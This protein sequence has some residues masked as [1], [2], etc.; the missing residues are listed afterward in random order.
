MPRTPALLLA[1]TLSLL[2]AAVPAQALELEVTGGS[3][4]GPMSLDVHPGYYPLEFMMVVPSFQSG[5]TPLSVFD[6][7]DPRT[8]DIGTDLLSNAWLGACGLDLHMRLG[9][10]QLGAVPAL[11]DLAIYF[12]AFTLLGGP[13]IID[14][15][16]NPAAF[17][18]GIAG[19][20]RQRFA[21]T[22]DDRAFG[23]VLPRLDRRW[24]VV[25]G[26]R[27]QLL[28]QNAHATTDVYDPFTD[29]FA[30]GPML[31]TPR[32]LHTATQLGDG[33]WLITGGVNQTNDPQALCEIY[34]PVLD[35]FTACA[36]MGTPRMG[37]TA[38]LLPNGKVL[39][40]GGL[41]AV[42]VTPTQLQAVR[43]AVDTTELYD[44]LLDSWTPGPNLRTPR[45][46]HAAITRP[47]GKVLLLGGISWDTV[48]IIGWLPAVRATCDLYDPAANSIVAGPSM[49]TSRSMSDPIDLG[50]GRWLLAGGISSLTL[51]NL[52]TPTANAEIY[53]AVANTWTS[54]G[55]MATA[56][57]NHKGF[58][59]G[60]GQFLLAGGGNGTILS[61]VALSSCEVFSTATNT[62]SPGPSLTSARAGAAAF[63][64]PQGQVQFFGGATTGG[65]ITNSTEWYYF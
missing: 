10:Y 25:G 16:S 32:S 31:T 23:V 41:Q 48:I 22:V 37:H 4:P 26:G 58:A 18:L 47:D 52:G 60:G 24:M 28:A 5:P 56:R 17:R 3:T 49:A 12:Q 43:D 14:R 33:R 15:I 50:N 29:T 51:T 63:L 36:P 21:F 57:G 64:T 11:Q 55:A 9:P 59:L 65:S 46:A 45:A 20:F 7:L 54:V 13:T 34:D 27:G 44:P 42:S 8:V 6:P 61:P 1:A 19:T 35:T 39:V 40:T 30:A 38:S 2:A 62:F 53:D